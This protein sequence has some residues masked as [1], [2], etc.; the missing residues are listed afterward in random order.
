MPKTMPSPRT[1]VITG[2]S[3]SRFEPAE[4]DAG[5][6]LH[7]LQDAARLE[8][9][10]SRHDGR[11]RDGISTPRVRAFAVLEA[12]ENVAA[13]NNRADGDAV[14]ESLAQADKIG[15]D[16]VALERVHGP[17]AAEIGLDLVQ[18]EQDIV[19]PAKKNSSD[20]QVGGGVDGNCRR[21]RD[22]A[23]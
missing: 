19:P 16:A 9:V 1:L 14:A 20:F 5:D 7:M 23:R 15:L 10:E 11:T 2:V 17:C 18:N 4:K 22:R 6:R 8:L 21:R 3:L 12:G 13:A